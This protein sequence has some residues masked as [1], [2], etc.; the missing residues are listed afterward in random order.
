VIDLKAVAAGTFISAGLALAAMGVSTSTAN[1]TPVSPASAGPQV[2]AQNGPGRGHG[3]GH[4]DDWWW[5]VPGPRQWDPVDACIG[6][7]GPFGYVQGS[8]CI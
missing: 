6:V 8:A 5:D 3:H 4:D 1:A 2:F 7:Q